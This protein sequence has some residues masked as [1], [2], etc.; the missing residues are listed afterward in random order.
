MDGL[1]PASKGAAR[2]GALASDS[3]QSSQPVVAYDAGSAPR[4]RGAQ[5]G[6]APM[7]LER[8]TGWVAG[9]YAVE[10]AA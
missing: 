6:D 2:Q 3:G 5:S 4:R 9:E 1:V 7:P 10:L 8:R